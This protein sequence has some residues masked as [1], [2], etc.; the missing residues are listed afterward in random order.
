LVDQAI[1]KTKRQKTQI[2]DSAYDDLSKKALPIQY[3]ELY[4]NTINI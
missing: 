3:L 4:V 1:E 2:S